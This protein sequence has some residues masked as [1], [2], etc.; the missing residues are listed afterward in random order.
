MEH[1]KTALYEAV[2]VAF[3]KVLAKYN[4]FAQGYI[5]SDVGKEIIEYLAEQGLGFEEHG[6][7]EDLSALIDLF[8]RNGF[9]DGLEVEPA[10]KGQNY[11]WK[12]LY[13]LDAYKKLYDSGENPF[14]A[15]PLNLCLYYMADKY[16]K[17][18]RLHRKVFDMNNRITVSQYEVVDKTMPSNAGF[19]PLVLESVRFF[20]AA[21]ERE[22]QYLS[23]ALTDALTNVGNRRYLIEEGKK[24]IQ[25]AQCYHLPLSVLMLDVDHFKNINDT[26]GHG[27]GDVALRT[28]ADICRKSVR[29]TDIV[30]RFGGD[31]FVFVLP[32]TALGSAADL[33]ERLRT[34][35][36]HS[37][38]CAGDGSSFTVTASIGVTTN[39][40]GSSDI[41]DMLSRADTALFKAKDSGRDRV[42]ISTFA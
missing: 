4:V 14:L 9:A 8:V 7:L 35:L 31:E 36:G 19:D 39:C 41:I 12:N 29:E 25:H 6:S 17:T 22:R 27:V 40:D 34:A 11:I 28:V 23:Q 20:E 3:G 18:L 37:K 21:R 16:N 38:I 42:V 30:C 26:Y 10:E 1:F 5:L 33:A 32:N 13:G 2:L 15:C 24:A